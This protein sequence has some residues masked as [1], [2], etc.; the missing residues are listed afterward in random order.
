M[1]KKLETSKRTTSSIMSIVGTVAS[2]NNGSGLSNQAHSSKLS[3]CI[4]RFVC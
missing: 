3:Y 4:Y 2:N 1:E